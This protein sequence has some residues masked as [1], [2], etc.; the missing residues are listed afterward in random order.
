MTF[1]FISFKSYDLNT[2]KYLCRN[3]LYSTLF[4]VNKILK[5]SDGWR[6]FFVFCIP[7]GKT[8]FNKFFNQYISSFKVLKILQSHWKLVNNLLYLQ[9]SKER[10][11]VSTL[12]L[13]NS[14]I[15]QTRKV[16]TFPANVTQTDLYHRYI[17]EG[18][19]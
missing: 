4:T 7:Q 14:L 9:V 17:H 16:T 2:S 11:P 10:D 6:I 8:G 15:L 13:L 3:C 5:P 19:S 1:C 12:H 18:D